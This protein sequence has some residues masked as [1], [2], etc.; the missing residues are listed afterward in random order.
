MKTCTKCDAE[1]PLE[2]FYKNANTKDALMH[3]CKACCKRYRS[4]NKEQERNRTLKA[5]YGIDLWEYNQM[6]EEQAGCCGI[7][8][9]HQTR[10]KRALAVDHCHETG[11]VR[12]LL[13]RECNTGIGSLGDTL[14]GV[15]RA[16]AYLGGTENAS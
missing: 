7:C 11:E 4:E 12:G 15:L 9:Q 14:E 3:Q 8:Q 6:F 1:K 5:K 10:F 16:A 2:E 13:C